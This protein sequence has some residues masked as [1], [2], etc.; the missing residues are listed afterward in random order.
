MPHV[1]KIDLGVMPYDKA[2]DLQRLHFENVLG[3]EQSILMVLEHPNVYTL[4]KSGNE[5]NL[6]VNDEFLRKINATYFKTDRGGDITFHGEGQIVLYPI[7]N[8]I[9]LNLSLRE[10]IEKLEQVVIDTIAKWGIIG[11]RIKTAT[12]V[13]LD[14]N[15]P[16]KARKIAAIGVK[17]SRGVT[18]HGMAFNVKTDLKY[19][20]YINPCGM[21]DKGVTSLEVEGVEIDMS[22]IKEMVCQNF[23][24]IFNVELI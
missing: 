18:M 2:L 24:R 15:N 3:G 13:W 9:E 20:S 22:G 4:G 5:N 12:G 1:T 21:A 6:L 10:Y 23:A 19:F 14:A 7:L 16:A 8:L 11:E 17:A